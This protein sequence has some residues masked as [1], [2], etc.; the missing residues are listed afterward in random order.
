MSKIAETTSTGPTRQEVEDAIRKGLELRNSRDASAFKE[1]RK[2]YN[3]LRDIYRASWYPRT[4]SSVKSTI[5]LLYRAACGSEQVYFTEGANGISA[6]GYIM[7]QFSSPAEKGQ[8]KVYP[9]YHGI[10]LDNTVRD[11]DVLIKDLTFAKYQACGGESHL[12]A[13]GLIQHIEKCNT[14]DWTKYGKYKV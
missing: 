3:Q 9:L 12:D 1:S 6:E 8:K 13:K 14:A 2:T 10:S 11:L 7:D 4:T 5:A